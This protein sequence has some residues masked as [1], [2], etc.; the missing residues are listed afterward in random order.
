MYFYHEH[1]H[2]AYAAAGED[3]GS[4][5]GS[6]AGRTYEPIRIPAI[7]NWCVAVSVALLVIVAAL[8]WLA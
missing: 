6:D 7:I 5:D 1:Y 4:Q 8:Q 2:D 3:L